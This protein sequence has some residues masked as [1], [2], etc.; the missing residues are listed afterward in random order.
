M[1]LGSSKTKES[2]EENKTTE[3]VQNIELPA[4]DQIVTNPVDLLKFE[5][6]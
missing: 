1:K 2:I 3:S 6:I 4:E 5:E